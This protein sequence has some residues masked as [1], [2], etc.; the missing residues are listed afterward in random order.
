MLQL[1]HLRFTRPRKDEN[2]FA[3]YI[4]RQ[5]EAA[6]SRA[7]SSEAV[8]D[9][10][11]TGAVF[12]DHP[13]LPRLMQPADFDGVKLERVAAIYQERFSSAKDFTFFLVGSFEVDKVKPLLATYL[14]SLPVSD[15]PTAIRDRGVRPATGVIKTDMYRGAEPGSRVS[16]RFTSEAPYSEEEAMRV[17]ALADVLNIKLVD[18]LRGE[19][20]LLYAGRFTGKMTKLPYGRVAFSANLPCASASAPQVVAAT[21]ALLR[22]VQEEGP[23]P[24]DLDKVKANWNASLRRARQENGYW[25]GALQGAYANGSDPAILLRE[26]QRI[27]ALTPAMLQEAARRYIKFDSH[28]QAVLHPASK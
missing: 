25:L 18:V 4:A 22:K 6:R 26:E 24:A 21:M 20:G 8:F 23:D 5:R 16:L 27:A 14:G 3:S 2:L 19:K 1:V 9:D 28:V 11:V 15:I 13:L 10:K 17:R 7:A 12:N